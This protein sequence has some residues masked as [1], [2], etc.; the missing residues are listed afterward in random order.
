MDPYIGHDLQIRN[1]NLLTS[2]IKSDVSEEIVSDISVSLGNDT[3][4]IQPLRATGNMLQT[5]SLTMRSVLSCFLASEIQF[6]TS[7]SI[8][9]P[10]KQTTTGWPVR[11]L[12]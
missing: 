2:V 1:D 7:S 8:V 4:C 5:R 11:V 9:D 3:N 10:F 6:R 12:V